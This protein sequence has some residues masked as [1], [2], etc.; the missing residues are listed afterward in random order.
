MART[1]GSTIST[2]DCTCQ[3]NPSQTNSDT[4]LHHFEWDNPA[5]VSCCGYTCMNQ[6]KSTGGNEPLSGFTSG[7]GVSSSIGGGK[8]RPILG[9]VKGARTGQMVFRGADG[10]MLEGKQEVLGMEV[11]KILIVAGVAVAAYFI[12]KK[13]K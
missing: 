13:L 1:C 3:D 12:V 8:P 7:G 6:C 9:S 2:C 4:P 10:K 5:G 11:P